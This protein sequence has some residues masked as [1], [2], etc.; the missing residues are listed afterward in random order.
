MEYSQ[1]FE[2]IEPFEPNLK[3][4][5]NLKNPYDPSNSALYLCASFEFPIAV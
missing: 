4:L 1:P 5:K 3:N 2:L